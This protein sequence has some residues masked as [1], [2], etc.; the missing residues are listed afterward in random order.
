M[1]I[2]P[3]RENTVRYV[4]RMAGELRK[5]ANTVEEPFLALLLEMVMTEGGIALARQKIAAEEAL[6]AE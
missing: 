4:I 6:K 3:N 1:D 5:M 2:Q